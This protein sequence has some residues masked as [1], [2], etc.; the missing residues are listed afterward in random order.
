MQRDFHF[1]ATYYA[2]RLAGFGLQDA[3][4]IAF[5]AE[6]IDHAGG[7]SG[8][9]LLLPNKKE[10]NT[11][12][13]T[14]FFQG[15]NTC[16]GTIALTQTG[17][18]TPNDLHKQVWAIFH[19]PPGNFISRYASNRPKTQFKINEMKTAGQDIKLGEI[20]LTNTDGY[21]KI[22]AFRGHFANPSDAK[23]SM[24]FEPFDDKA[25]KHLPMINRPHSPTAIR[26]IE[27][28]AQDFRSYQSRD[29]PNKLALYRIGVA[30]H[31]YSDTWAHQD[32]LGAAD[33]EFNKVEY[34]KKYHKGY[35]NGLEYSS[36]TVADKTSLSPWGGTTKAAK[37][38]FAGNEETPWLGHGPMGSWPDF[39][40]ACYDWRPKWS[41]EIIHRNNPNEYLNAFA[42]LIKAM[43]WIRKGGE[44]E[45]YTPATHFE[46]IQPIIGS[47]ALSAFKNVINS[48]QTL[49]DE[50][51]DNRA[52]LWIAE[53]K[54]LTDSNNVPLGLPAEYLRAEFEEWVA[55][56][57]HRW[58]S[59][60]EDVKEEKKM[61]SRGDTIKG[62]LIG[63]IAGE[64]L[65][66]DY[67]P[68]KKED[69][70]SFFYMR[71]KFLKAEKESYESADDFI[72][73]DYFAFHQAAK[74]HFRAMRTCFRDEGFALLANDNIIKEALINDLDFLSLY[75][76]WNNNSYSWINSS[77]SS[78]FREIE[79][80]FVSAISKASNEEEQ[81]LL[82][83][84]KE[85]ILVEMKDD[86]KKGKK[87][88]SESLDTGLISEMNDSIKQTFRN[89]LNYWDNPRDFAKS[90]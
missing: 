23:L 78:L 67:I 19:F 58:F 18:Q 52:K 89:L 25:R 6:Y 21:H 53:F 8:S 42:N 35:W 70:D 55:P 13:I 54:G 33:A 26:T 79:Y 75:S 86:S 87:L 90:K 65:G 64:Y 30:I 63:K 57:K 43:K 37:L 72:R 7:M 69:W 59:K 4:E 73:S 27:A 29:L 41:S 10:I 39:P 81:M 9:S 36:G 83:V 20:N 24:K 76:I 40:W 15:L 50:K 66:D 1:Y 5:A 62:K 17:N 49:K 68:Q 44:G 28:A 45:M 34:F 12:G 88:L 14:Y 46:D 16:N 48:M 32:H 71:R 61:K 51:P 22:R 47:A 60:N 2:A 77:Y 84:I 74:D 85:G 80:A 56:R 38:T 31:V 11:G 82:G 3:T